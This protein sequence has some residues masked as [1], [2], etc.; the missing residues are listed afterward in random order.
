MRLL[1]VDAPS[2]SWLLEDR[3]HLRGHLRDV[4]RAVR[5]GQFAGPENATRRAALLET[6]ETLQQQPDLTGRMWI[7]IANVYAEMN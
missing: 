2:F 3:Y 6:L 1:T 7:A 5:A 4:R